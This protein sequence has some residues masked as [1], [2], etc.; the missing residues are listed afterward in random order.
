M[1]K[2]IL[3]GRLECWTKK[4]TERDEMCFYG[5]ARALCVTPQMTVYEY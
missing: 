3:Y 5:D 1:Q 4:E 2:R